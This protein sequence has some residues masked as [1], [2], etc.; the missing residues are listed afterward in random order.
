M[1]LPKRFACEHEISSE[2]L[3]YVAIDIVAI[4]RKRM[5]KELVDRVFG[6]MRDGEEYKISMSTETSSRVNGR[7]IFD[8]GET[9]LEPYAYTRG[10][11][12]LVLRTSLSL[13]EDIR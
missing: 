1:T 13:K 9:A 5:Q 12:S 10:I 7:E 8:G 11:V 3:R 6:E 4:E 2:I